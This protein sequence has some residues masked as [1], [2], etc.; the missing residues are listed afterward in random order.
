LFGSSRTLVRAEDVYGEALF[1]LSMAV[2]QATAS[3][4]ALEAQE[5]IIKQ[6]AGMGF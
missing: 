3:M 4:H 1:A 2:D 6:A 5:T